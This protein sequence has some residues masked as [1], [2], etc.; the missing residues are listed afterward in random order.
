M[1]VPVLTRIVGAD[2]IRVI[3]FCLGPDLAAKVLDRV[4]CGFV[5]RQN[6][7]RTL[8]AQHLMDGLKNLP[9]AA[10]PDPI[11]NHVRPER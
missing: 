5:E 4:R 8:A 10:L 11:G 3:Q 9:H 7:D 1:H 6:F 2:K